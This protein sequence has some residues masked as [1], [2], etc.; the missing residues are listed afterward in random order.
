[1]CYKGTP[2]SSILNSSYSLSPILPS[3]N[4]RSNSSRS[5]F[6]F[7]CSSSTLYCVFQFR[8]LPK[9]KVL[10]ICFSY[11]LHS[12]SYPFYSLNWLVLPLYSVQS[13]TLPLFP[14]FPHA[15]LS[16]AHTTSVPGDD[17]L[18]FLDET[19]EMPG[20]SHRSETLF[21]PAMPQNGTSP[22]LLSMTQT[23]QEKQLYFTSPFKPLPN[24]E[25]LNME[26]GTTDT[27]CIA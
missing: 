27:H 13:Y 12:D 24:T 17:L 1:M 9:L 5:A 23:T 10:F 16:S 11:T 4:S 2:T 21:C 26:E 18:P 15:L 6:S 25:G 7:C 14:L 3:I 22:N 19:A 8:L 20:Y